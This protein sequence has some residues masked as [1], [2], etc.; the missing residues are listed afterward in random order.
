MTG[1]YRG[2]VTAQGHERVQRAAMYRPP[3]ALRPYLSGAA[4]EQRGFPPSEHVGLPSCSITLVLPLEGPLVVSTDGRKRVAMSACVGGLHAGPVTIVHD[5]TQVGFHLAVTPDGSRALF[6]CPAAE[7]AGGVVELDELWGSDG[8]ELLERLR[9]ADSW[10]GRAAVLDEMLLRRLASARRR[11][12]SDDLSQAWSRLSVGIPGTTVADVAEHVGWSRRHLGGRFVAEFG[13]SPK[14]V[15][16]I[17]RLQSAV[18]R[19]KR[20]P[21]ERL[22]DVAARCGYSD[23]A[24]LARDWRDLAGCTTSEWLRAEV[25]PFVQDAAGAAGA[26]LA[27]DYS[28]AHHDL[29]VP[30][31]P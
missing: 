16:R 11:A 8:R 12:E 2:Q 15:Q 30:G 24:H 22:A 28:I 29:A 17:A 1:R 19:L 18:V 23:Q 13:L 10:S 4:Y 14:T 31:Q 5:G 7:L 26:D 27:D 3:A 20:W 6:G 9:I 21:T 25:L